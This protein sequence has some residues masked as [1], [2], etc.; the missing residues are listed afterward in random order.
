L[1]DVRE[2]VVIATKVF[3][4][5]GDKPNQRGPLQKAHNASG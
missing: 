3:G 2:D 5:M 1:K 4:A